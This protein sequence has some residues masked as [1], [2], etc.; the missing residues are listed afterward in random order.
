MLPILK[1]RLVFFSYIKVPKDLSGKYYQKGLVK[2]ITIFL[3]KEKEKQQYGFEIVRSGE[4]LHT[5][6]KNY[7][8]YIFLE[9]RISDTLY[10]L[11]SL[12]TKS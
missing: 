8:F 3:K 7:L 5:L 10:F 12:R 9:K 1:K 2:S 11:Y 4:I 6:N